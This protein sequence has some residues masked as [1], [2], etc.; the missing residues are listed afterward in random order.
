[1]NGDMLGA[2]TPDLIPYKWIQ[3]ELVYNGPYGM[4]NK[5]AIIG[6]IQ[7]WLSLQGNHLSIDRDFG[8][9]TLQAVTNFQTDH[10]IPV[11]NQVDENTF[12]LL[13]MPMLRALTPLPTDSKSYNELVV[14]YASQHLK[15]HPLEIGGQNKGPWVRLYMSGNEG[16][17]W[18]WCAG[19]VCFILRLA[20]DT[21]KISM[22]LNPTVSCDILAAQAKEKGIFISERSLKQGTPSREEMTPGSIFLNRRTNNDWTHTGF[23]TAFHDATIETIE[24][25][26]ND[27]GDREGYEVCRRIRNYDGKDFIRIT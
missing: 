3:K 16:S 7:E 25:N 21:L 19:F 10:Q 27:N 1:M 13:T 22:P 20:A 18:P 4:R 17:Q 8:T 9:A 2:I 15:E 24:G 26:T 12:R 23:V 14:A 11:T 5:G 6:V